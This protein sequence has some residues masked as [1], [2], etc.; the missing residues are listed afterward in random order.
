MD[1]SEIIAADEEI[2]P[3]WV[4]YP[5]SATFQVL[6]RPIGNKQAEFFEKA[7]EVGWDETTM[8]RKIT[9]NEDA[10]LRL[11]ADWVIA[12]WK[13]LT[14]ADLK[15]LVLLKNPKKLKDLTGEIACDETAKLLLLKHAPAFSAW[16]NRVATD[17]ERF[18]R[19]REEGQKKT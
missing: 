12:G 9:I 18:N 15:R 5:E 17:I 2:E 1:L 7:R 13:G 8:E 3:I 6:V 11:F 19:E 10:Y 14:L 16:I 4:A